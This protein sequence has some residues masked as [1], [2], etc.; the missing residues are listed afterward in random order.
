MGIN[1][2]P[3]TGGAGNYE[4][5]SE[6]IDPV[7]KFRVSQPENLIDTDFEYGLQPTKWETVELINNTPSFFSKSGDTTIDGISSIIT[8]AGTREIIVK[9][10]LDHG[11]AVGIPINVTG[12]KSITAD[13]SYIINSIP[14]TKTF[15]YLCKDDQ[16]ETA[17]IL[18]LY[19]S[20]ITGEF[21]Q[22]SQLRVSD[23]EGIVTDAAGTSSLTVTTNSTHGFGINTPFYFLNLN[24]TV[25]QEFQA[26]NT[27]S[28]TFDASNSA[29]AQTFDGSNTLSS[30]NVDWSN[31]AVEGGTVSSI[32]STDTA[33]S[34]IT[35]SHTTEN[36]NERPVGTPLYYNIS[37]TSGYFQSNPRGVVFLKTTTSLGT[38]TSTFQV[39]LVP[40]GEPILFTTSLS[41]TFQ[42]ANQART[43]AGNNV[44]PVTQTSITII[45]DSPQTFDGTNSSGNIA[46]VVSYSGGNITITPQSGLADLGWY[47]DAM[48]FYSTSGAVPTGL[49]NN[50]T[51]W[52]V[53]V[54]QTPDTTN[55]VMTIKATPTSSAITSISGSGGTFT[56]IGVSLDKDWVHIQNHGYS[57]G[58]ML[59]YSYPVSGRIGTAEENTDYYWVDNVPNINNFQVGITK[60]AVRDGSTS[61]RAAN[62]IADLKNLGISTDGGYWL[63]PGLAGNPYQTYIRFN[64]LDGNDWQLILKVHNR[65]DMPSGSPFWTNSTLQ[66]ANDM[67]LTSGNWS[68]YAAWN[69]VSFNRLAM[70]MSP[71]RVPP[72]M[73]FNTARTMFQACTLRN[74]TGGFQGISAD[75]S[76]PQIGTSISYNNMPMKQGAAFPLQTGTENIIQQYGIATFANNAANGTTDNAGLPSLGRAGAWVGF[77]IDEGPHSFGSLPQ[78]GADSGFGFGGGAGNLRRTWSAGY[79]Q[80]NTSEVVNTLPGYLWV[81]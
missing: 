53:S 21:F 60:G 36:F 70:E 19:S 15:T 7:S 25:A 35:V 51:Y 81:R 59:R 45:E 78:G 57:V 18:D 13:G 11:L 67:N 65:G 46:N 47:P 4:F 76:D 71:G 20:I 33:N 72:I 48:I 64:Y 50:T 38:S 58:D 75:S 80:W 74:Y 62:S 24:S 9:T 10:E 79:G 63:D 52:V 2:F 42:V 44:N 30:F 23:S 17:S 56:K 8:N 37:A 43:F 6:L 49:T 69:R 12:T 1:S 41:G 34:R 27:A 68:K 32:T 16:D 28:K 3:P 77:A 22:G 55:Y 29:T 61:L 26:A 39:S 5:P 66:N 73:I 14:D 40:D 31:S 54:A